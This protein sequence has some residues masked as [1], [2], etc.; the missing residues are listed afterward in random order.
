MKPDSMTA[1][2]RTRSTAACTSKSSKAESAACGGIVDP[3]RRVLEFGVDG[4]PLAIVS[5]L[6]DR[7]VE[8]VP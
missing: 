3:D 6:L 2:T 5:V 7:S 8:R 4:R 1:L